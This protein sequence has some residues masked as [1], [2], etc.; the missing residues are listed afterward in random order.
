MELLPHRL[1]DYLYDLCIFY[2]EYYD[3]CY[4]LEKDRVTGK[5]VGLGVVRGLWRI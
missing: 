3:N 4:C 1:C 2:T 5:V